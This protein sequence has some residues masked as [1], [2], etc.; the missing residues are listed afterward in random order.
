MERR[1]KLMKKFFAIMGIILLC[2]VCTFNTA[3]ASG[4]GVKVNSQNVNFSDATPFIDG[5]GRTLVP[6]RAIA[7]ALDLQ[8]QWD[9]SKQSITVSMERTDADF[10][11]KLAFSYGQLQYGMPHFSNSADGIR[12]VKQIFYVNSNKMDFSY[13]DEQV[14]DTLNGEID[15]KPVIK[16]GRTYLPARYI[17]E[18]FGYSVGWN[19]ATQTV[20]I[21]SAF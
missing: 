4:V 5:N 3:F 11:K 6:M 2:F 15:T 21:Q 10:Q 13:S 9:G 19:S 16:D 20:T 12:T 18:A 14:T 1:G 7:E 17:A 8:V